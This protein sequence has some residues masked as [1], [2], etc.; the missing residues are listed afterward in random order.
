MKVKVQSTY[1]AHEAIG[2]V[3]AVSSSVHTH[4]Y[5]EANDLTPQYCLRSLFVGVD[6]SFL[7][8]VC[9]TT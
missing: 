5:R 1:V 2:I 4:L 6:A 8:Q 9:R 7:L 3:V